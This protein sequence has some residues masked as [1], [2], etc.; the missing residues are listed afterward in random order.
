MSVCPAC[1]HPT[2][3]IPAVFGMPQHSCTNEECGWSGT[4][5]VEV[6]FEDYKEFVKQQQ[7]ENAESK[8]NE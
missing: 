3:Y 4:I 6:N 7:Q 2:K 5:A 1:F 8:N